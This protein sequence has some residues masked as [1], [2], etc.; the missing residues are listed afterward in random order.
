MAGIM[1]GKKKDRSINRVY[2]VGW[3]VLNPMR[4]MPLL[5]LPMSPLLT[6]PPVLNAVMEEV[7]VEVELPDKAGAVVEPPLADITG[8]NVLFPADVAL[9]PDYARLLQRIKKV[10]HVDALN[11]RS[12]PEAFEN[13]KVITIVGK[14][15]KGTHKGKDGI[16]FEYS[17]FISMMV[18]HDIIDLFLVIGNVAPLQVPPISVAV[19]TPYTGTT[20]RTAAAISATT[21]DRTTQPSTPL[22]PLSNKIAVI[23]SIPPYP[24]INEQASIADTTVPQTNMMP[25]PYLP[26]LSRSVVR[27]LTR[28]ST[29]ESG[30]CPESESDSD[31]DSNQVT[32]G[33]SDPLVD[34]FGGVTRG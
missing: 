24:T 20:M 13:Y 9:W 26:S 6:M 7:V 25:R 29:N 34:G 19:A 4:W 5:L 22:L 30:N 3:V 1:M 33:Y 21:N 8:R 32:S 11:C 16:N 10:K 17:S 14:Q 2:K 12:P 28:V 27:I 15:G 31:E 23:P 18:K